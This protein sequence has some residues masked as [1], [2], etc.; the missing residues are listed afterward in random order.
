MSE[1]SFQPQ[2]PATAPSAW[3]RRFAPLI[4]ASGEVLDL[5]CGGGRHTRLLHELGYGVE[6]VDRDAA[7]LAELSGLPGVTTRAADL[8][9]G[10]WPY[11]GRAFAG[12]V[13]TNYL[14]RPLLPALLDALGEEGVL[15]YETFML[16]NERFGKPSN[17][18]F[19]L[20]PGELLEM[21]QGTHFSV[22]AFE[23][24]EVASPRPAVIQRICARRG[25]PLRLPP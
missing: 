9:G 16:G 2:A 11:R 13:V 3:V 6:A 22:I 20:R 23:Q 17:P 18:Q 24:G 19:L 7:A 10:P 4:P 12:I 1:T 25:G 14:W 21:V 5:A 15:I 8:E